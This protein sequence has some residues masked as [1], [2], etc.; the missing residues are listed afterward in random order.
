MNTKHMLKQKK[1]VGLF[2]ISMCFS[3]PNNI[4]SKITLLKIRH[5][6]CIIPTYIRTNGQSEVSIPLHVTS[7]YKTLCN[8]AA[9]LQKT[10]LWDR[11]DW[12]FRKSEIFIYKFNILYLNYLSEMQCFMLHSNTLDICWMHC[13]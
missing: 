7:Y 2:Q 10:H 8:T 13:S 4:H 9:A 12:K 5:Y 11:S 6:W 3:G 1:L